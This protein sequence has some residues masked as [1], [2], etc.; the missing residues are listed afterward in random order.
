MEILKQLSKG[1]AQFLS[2]IYERVC[3]VL[4]KDLNKPTR[5]MKWPE[6]VDL[7]AHHRLLMLYA[8]CGLT[9]KKDGSVLG[10]LL[11]NQKHPDPDVARDYRSFNTVL[12][13]LIRLGLLSR[14]G[15]ESGDDRYHITRVG[16]EFV[17]ACRMPNG[18]P[19]VDPF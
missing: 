12:G 1:E 17:R 2:A 5:E 11:N 16:Y 18:S 15:H 13:N 6:L 7:G 10:N 19:E 8:E 4:E 9:K 14:D 3:H